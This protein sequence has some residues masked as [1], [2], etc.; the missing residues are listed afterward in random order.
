[1]P[2]IAGVDSIEI[3]HLSRLVKGDG[4]AF[5]VR[6]PKLDT[7]SVSNGELSDVGMKHFGRIVGLKRLTV[8]NCKITDAGLGHLRSL[9]KLERLDISSRNITDAGLKYVRELGSLKSLS[10]SLKSLGL[11]AGRGKYWDVGLRRQRPFDRLQLVK[12]KGTELTDQWRV[13]YV[14]PQGLTT[15]QVTL[16]RSQL[17]AAGLDFLES[18]SQFQFV[19]VYDYHF[20]EDGKL[21]RTMH[22]RKHVKSN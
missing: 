14:N 13:S 20:Y 9:Q 16:S 5:L 21:D 18:L 10:L 11:T 12:L 22:L 4:L 2:S 15:S 8:D 19:E 3:L 1:M 17:N 6:L 7:V